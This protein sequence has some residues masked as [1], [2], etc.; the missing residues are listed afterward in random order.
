[1]RKLT[2]LC[3]PA[4]SLLAGCATSQSNFTPYIA[5]SYAPRA[6]TYSIAVIA[7]GVEPDRPFL[8]L[9]EVYSV[10]D[11]HF[12]TADREALLPDLIAQTRK[13][14]GDAVMNLR[15][16]RDRHLESVRYVLSATAIRYTD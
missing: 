11:G 9:G 14:G 13:A 1:M 2:V 8:R 15:E 3:M 4:V 10:R 12:N 5:Q 16:E 7:D 6:E